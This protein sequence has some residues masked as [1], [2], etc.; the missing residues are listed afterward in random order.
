MMRQTVRQGKAR[1]EQ[2]ELQKTGAAD[3]SNYG[4]CLPRYV[5]ACPSMSLLIACAWTQTRSL[6]GSF[7][8]HLSSCLISYPVYN[9]D[10]AGSL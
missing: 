2:K 8:R 3:F 1:Q 7:F 5:D 4:T 6:L 10:T 9:N